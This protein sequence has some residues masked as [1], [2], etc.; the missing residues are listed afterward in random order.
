[1]SLSTGTSSGPW[2]E[3]NVTPLI[4]VLLVLLI[5]FMVIVPLRQ[6]GMDSSIPQ[7]K[8]NAI[9]PQPAVV[10]LRAGTKPGEVMYRVNQHEVA[11]NALGPALRGI[12]AAQPGRTVLVD[13]DRELTYEPVAWVAG[14]AKR[15]GASNLILS[16]RR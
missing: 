12:F 14:E 5:I 8:A 10:E 16:V 6:R 15:Q 11:R 2:A 3:I 1:M 7:D 4:D 9:A 13:A